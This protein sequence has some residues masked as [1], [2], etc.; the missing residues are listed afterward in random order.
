MYSSGNIDVQNWVYL[1]ESCCILIMLHVVCFCVLI[2]NICSRKKGDV[3]EVVFYSNDMYMHMCVNMR[4][5]LLSI[6]QVW[7]YISSCCFGFQ[8]LRM[9]EKSLSCGKILY[10]WDERYNLLEGSQDSHKQNLAC[11]LRNIIGDI[12]KN[13][14]GNPCVTAKYIC[15]FCVLGVT[16]S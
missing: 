11:R 8:M 9:L 12:E 15:K 1:F 10:Y 6:S 3:I 7:N 14:S 13:I 2:W 5:N 16:Y 4:L